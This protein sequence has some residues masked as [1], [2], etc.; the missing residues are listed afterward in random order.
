MTHKDEFEMNHK[1]EIEFFN[2]LFK[3]DQN[4]QLNKSVFKKFKQ[5]QT[6]DSDSD[7]E[8]R[9]NFQNDLA[10]TIVGISFF[11]ALFAIL[12]WAKSGHVEY[13][14][15]AVFGAC[16]IGIGNL[17]SISVNDKIDVLDKKKQVEN[18]QNL[19]SNELLEKLNWETHEMPVKDYGS[20]IIRKEHCFHETKQYYDL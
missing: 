13:A 17:F 15:L 12:G 14:I 11:L 6:D 18:S 20:I 9:Y 10:I 2:A 16:G 19:S 7:L 5:K 1:D 3:A 4:G 8:E